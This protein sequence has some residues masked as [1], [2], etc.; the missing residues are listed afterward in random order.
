M[1]T[2]RE[3]VEGRDILRS[4]P[5]SRHVCFLRGSRIF[6]LDVIDE[7]GRLMAFRTLKKH[8]DDLLLKSDQTESDSSSPYPPAALLTSLPRSVW[9]SVRSRLDD[10]ILRRIDRSLFVVSLDRTAPDGEKGSSK[11]HTN[12]IRQW[13]CGDVGIRGRPVE[14][15]WYDKLTIAVAPD[16]SAGINFE[17]S[18]YDAVP[19]LRL[20]GEVHADAVG[21]NFLPKKYAIAT[22]APSQL[23]ELDI[24]PPE[25]VRSRVLPSAL[26]AIRKLS[27][28]TKVH[29]LTLKG[30]GAKRLKSWG[31]SPDGIAQVAF[32]L[33]YRAQHGK[34]AYPT[35][36]VY[37]S[38]ATN[39][40]RHGRTEAGRT[41]TKESVRFVQG[42]VAYVENGTRPTESERRRFKSLLEDACVAH[43]ERIHDAS[44]ACG[45]DRHLFALYKIALEEAPKNPLPRIFADPLWSR[46][47]TSVLSTSRVD[48]TDFVYFI[49]Y[50]PVCAHGYGVPYMMGQTALHLGLTS[51]SSPPDVSGGFGGIS[52]SSEHEDGGVSTGTDSRLYGQ[53]IQKSFAFLGRICEEPVSSRL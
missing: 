1:G 48:A 11:W 4:F 13:L 42:A 15:R 49:S 33:A 30:Y 26:A 6:A 32:Q 31:M 50:G 2:V 3:A 18:P 51:F 40:F 20:L 46:L 22:M 14:P 19:L 8:I 52:S 17:H 10:D 28:Q 7:R 24:R 36:S 38:V 39:R 44:A 21:R 29:A 12:A 41:V 35:M 23:R 53:W 5:E 43:S 47:N 37:E 27:D 16:G 45:V 9:A 34:E 25:Y